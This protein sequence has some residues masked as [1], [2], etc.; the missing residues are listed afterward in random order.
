MCGI[1]G[2][3]LKKFSKNPKSVLKKMSEKIYHRG[4]D[5]T[6]LY[7]D[8]NVAMGIQR[9]SILDIKNGTQPIYSNN[10][11][12]VIV[13]NGEEK[14]LEVD[15]VIIC[16]GQTPKRNLFPEL[17]EAG[18]KVHLV[19]GAHEAKELDAKG[20]IKEATLLALKI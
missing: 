8:D 7:I 6:G 19:G 2:F 10:K 4:P 13:H 11:R 14:T 18:V 5:Q 12:Y 3:S 16:S 1:Y 15:H 20:A 17:E 9:L